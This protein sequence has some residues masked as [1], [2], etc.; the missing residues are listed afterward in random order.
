MT[1]CQASFLVSSLLGSYF[2]TKINIYL[3]RYRK[4]I[5]CFDGMLSHLRQIQTMLPE[6]SSPERLDTEEKSEVATVLL[7]LGTIC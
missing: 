4:G 6:F 2:L 1:F 5:Y 7:M 3:S